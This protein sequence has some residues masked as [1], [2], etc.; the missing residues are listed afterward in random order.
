MDKELLK[1]VEKLC[2]DLTN[3]MHTHGNIPVVS[4]QLF[5]RS[6]IHSIYSEEN[7]QESAWG[8]I[9]KKKKKKK[10]NFQEGDVLKTGWKTPA[11]NQPEEIF[12]MGTISIL[13]LWIVYRPFKIM[14][15]IFGI[16]ITS[17][18]EYSFLLMC[19]SRRRKT[20]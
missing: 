14:D 17:L 2:E 6:K 7:G 5:C 4:L 3:A 1:L 8:F 10:N 9:N 20:R 13:T 16:V 11:L 15:M 18:W 19:N 12:S